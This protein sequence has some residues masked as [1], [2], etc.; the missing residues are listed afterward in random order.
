MMSAGGTMMEND[1]SPMTIVFTCALPLAIL[2][3][4]MPHPLGP[5]S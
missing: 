5:A 1:S 3:L 4:R 2:C